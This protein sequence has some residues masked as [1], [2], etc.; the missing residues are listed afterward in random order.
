MHSP[1][2]RLEI[3]V[4]APSRRILGGQAIQAER[5]LDSWRDDPDVRAW[6][7]PINPELP[8]LVRPLGRVKYV[9]TILT[10]LAYWPLLFRE[11]RRADVVHVFSASYSS[12]LLAP[13]P[14]VLVAWILGKPIV[15]NYHSGE[16]PDHLRRSAIARAVLRRVD[17]NVVPSAFLERVFTG[18]ELHAEVVSNTVDVDQFAFRAREPLGPRL[19]S[20]RNLE[21]LYN[22][23]CTLRAF[24]RVQQ[25]FPDATLTLV[26]AGSRRSALMQLAEELG[27]SHVHFVGA[28]R[29]QD[30]WRC[31][32][33]ADIYVQT[34]DIDNMPLS[35]LEAFA[36]GCPVVSTDAGGVPAIVTDRTNGLLVPCGDAEAAAHCVIEL[37]ESP[38]LARA[39]A[40]NARAACDAYRWST[41][42]PSWLAVYRRVAKRGAL[43]EPRDYDAASAIGSADP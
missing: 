17:A 15:L 12:F 13:L 23:E 10:Q 28:V 34:P 14:A 35:I 18:F 11:L 32:A 6:L 27:L 33:D 36:S 41:V 40:S 20:T 9:R 42:R 39:I 31:Y 4:V 8:R 1:H 26:G 25:Q 24:Q 30:I 22:V 38:E 21:S 19:V 5:L 2:S 29:P 43:G 7:V 3:A 37:L 16:A